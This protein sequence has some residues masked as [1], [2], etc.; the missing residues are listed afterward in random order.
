MLTER[1]NKY[2]EEKKEKKCAMRRIE[3]KNCTM[4]G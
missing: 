1:S 2:R 4:M 3:R